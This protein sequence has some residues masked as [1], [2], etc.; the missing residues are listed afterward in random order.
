MHGPVLALVIPMWIFIDFN[1][2]IPY[3]RCV[4]STHVMKV[5]GCGSHTVMMRTI[6]SCNAMHIT[7][8]V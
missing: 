8:I 2:C 6:L 5:T 3:G 1:K 7:V 4:S